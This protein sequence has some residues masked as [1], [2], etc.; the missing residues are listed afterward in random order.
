VPTS[1]VA[2]TMDDAL[3]LIT[4]SNEAGPRDE[5]KALFSAK[6]IIARSNT[7]SYESK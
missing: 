6:K 3:R 1:A 7:C 5:R 4:E 2:G